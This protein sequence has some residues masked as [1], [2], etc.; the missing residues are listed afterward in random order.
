MNVCFNVFAVEKNSLNI[1]S[2]NARLC[3]YYKAYNNNIFIGRKLSHLTIAYHWHEVEC[4]WMEL[5]KIECACLIEHKVQCFSMIT[6]FS[7]WI[8]TSCFVFIQLWF[9]L[10]WHTLHVFAYEAD[11]SAYFWC[12]LVIWIL[13]SCF[14]GLCE[15]EGILGWIFILEV[16]FNWVIWLN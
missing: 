10:K 12:A 6:I 16:E 7:R 15:G 13:S 5:N 14:C 11:I 3:F 2:C 9:R 1:S 4:N 8:S